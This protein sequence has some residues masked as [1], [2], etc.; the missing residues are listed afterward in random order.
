MQEDDNFGFVSRY[1]VFDMSCGC[2]SMSTTFGGAPSR[3]EYDGM[4][5]SYVGRKT[6]VSC[7]VYLQW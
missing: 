3:G 4:V 2:I 7:D 1:G 5:Q 6:V